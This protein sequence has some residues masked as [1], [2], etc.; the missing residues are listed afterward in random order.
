MSDVEQAVGSH[1]A[2]FWTARIA[3]GVMAAILGFVIVVNII[4]P[5]GENAPTGMEWLGLA[6][7]PGGVFVGYALAFMWPMTGA[8][9]ALGCLLGWLVYIGFEPGVLVIAAVVG[10]PGVLYVIHA[11][12][13]RRKEPAV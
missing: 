11:V 12:K 10:A 2:L 8:C 5:T 3:G 4:N 1:R 7:F 9:V 6:M 13:A